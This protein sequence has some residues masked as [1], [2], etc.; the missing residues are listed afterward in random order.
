MELR[1]YQSPTDRQ[2]RV[3]ELTKR[4]AVALIRELSESLAGMGGGIS[5]L[6]VYDTWEKDSY[7]VMVC[8]KEDKPTPPTPAVCLPGID[9]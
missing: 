8:V 2:V 5:P 6:C 3:M 9:D 7:R 1:G 4:E